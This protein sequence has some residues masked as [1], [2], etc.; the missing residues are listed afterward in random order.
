MNKEYYYLEGNE[1]KGPLSIDKLNT[2]GLK[3]NTLV[4]AEG[5]DDWKPIKEVDELKNLL[6]I[7]PPPPAQPQSPP[8]PPK[9][10]TMEVKNEK[11]YSGEMPNYKVLSRYC[12]S[13]ICADLTLFVIGIINPDFT[14]S[15]G[16]FLFYC[17]FFL[18]LMFGLRQHYMLT[19]ANRPIPFKAYIW[20][21]VGMY[22]LFFIISIPNYTNIN[23][24]I[25]QALGIIFLPVLIPLCVLEIIV[26]SK[27]KNRLKEAYNIGIL[28]IISAIVSAA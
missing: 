25:S 28:M 1:Q 21:G 26:G 3:P 10:E 24:D 6:K 11:Y 27:L 19:H 2:V 20:L 14:W 12:I 7:P 5:L 22:L 17:W 8:P 15:S 13:L 16:I 9:Q 4:W 23:E 18:Y